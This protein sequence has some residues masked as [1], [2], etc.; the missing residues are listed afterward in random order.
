MGDTRDDAAALRAARA[1]RPDLAWRFA[2]VGPDRER[3]IQEADLHAPTLLDLLPL[4]KEDL[5]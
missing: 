1:A 5:P 4:L 2:G 3:F